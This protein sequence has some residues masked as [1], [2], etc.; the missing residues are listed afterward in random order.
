MTQYWLSSRDCISV[1][2]EGIV[3]QGMYTLFAA[4]VGIGWGGGG[5]GGGGGGRGGKWDAG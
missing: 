1:T 4:D 3:N 5:G 2:A